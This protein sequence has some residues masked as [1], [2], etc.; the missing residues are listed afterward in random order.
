[1]ITQELLGDVEVGG[2]HVYRV[3]ELGI[4]VHNMSTPNSPC[5][6]T[7]RTECDPEFPSPP[8]A[9][10]YYLQNKK[11]PNTNF[12]RASITSAGQFNYDVENTPHDGKGCPGTWLFEQACMYFEQQNVT[13]NG[14]RGDWTFGTNLATINSLTANNQ[15]TL[16]E[17]AVHPTLWAFQRAS[18][19]GYTNV[20]ILD[21]DG[22]PGN[23]T[24]VDVLYTP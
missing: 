15:M 20:T 18:S 24:S 23:Y 4:L 14:I 7:N 19:K 9:A 22:S 3:G 17:A 16:E 6:P 5:P 10:L 13:I 21:S 12:I 1:M 2:G 11:R 8:T